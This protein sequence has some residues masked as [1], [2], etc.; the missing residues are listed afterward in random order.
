MNKTFLLTSALAAILLCSGCVSPSAS[1]LNKIELGMTRTE[2]IEQMGEPNHVSATE[3]TEYLIYSLTY[4][5]DTFVTKEYFVR[6]VDGNVN[7]YGRFGDFDST[8]DPKLQID[9][10]ANIK[11]E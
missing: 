1:K 2:V 10:D 6:L 8:K 4:R 7:A 3:D 5:K 9:L 11:S